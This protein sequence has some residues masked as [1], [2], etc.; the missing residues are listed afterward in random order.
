MIMLIENFIHNP[1]NAENFSTKALVVQQVP[2][3]IL[4]RAL[5]L[6]QAKAEA[7]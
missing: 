3:A 4:R 7:N 5:T 1:K 2:F 6:W